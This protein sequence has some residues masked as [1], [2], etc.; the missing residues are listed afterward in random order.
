M[1]ER[2]RKYRNHTKS[3]SLCVTPEYYDKLSL[4]SKQHNI[5]IRQ[6]IIKSLVAYM[7]NHPANR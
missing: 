5:P 3:I 6:I 2:Q 1:D 4:Y 7:N